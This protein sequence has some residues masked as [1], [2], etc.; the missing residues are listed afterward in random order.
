MS[1]WPQ[2]A[3]LGLKGN[4][5]P[6]QNIKVMLVV[7]NDNRIIIYYLSDNSIDNANKL[8]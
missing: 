7:F 1:W 8:S 4:T 6:D 2:L 5:R 3:S